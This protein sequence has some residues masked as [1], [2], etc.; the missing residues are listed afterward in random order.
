M[1]KNNPKLF[2]EWAIKT[3]EDLESAII[4][5][6]ETGPSN[7]LCFHSH[8]AVENILK[9]FLVFKNNE[10]PKIHDL[11]NL[12]NLCVEIDDDFNNLK[13]EVSFLNRFYIETRYPAEIIDHPKE[14]CKKSVEFADKI[15]QFIV[16]KVV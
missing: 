5:F 4:L 14:E 1:A 11:I 15:V 12:L 9:G 8:Q 3:Q 2:K 7:S 16:N 6:N 10:F 13:D